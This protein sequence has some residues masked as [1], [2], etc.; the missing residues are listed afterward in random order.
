MAAAPPSLD[1]P[2]QAVYSVHSVDSLWS[3]A[4]GDAGIG[5]GARDGRAA[6]HRR[7]PRVVSRFLE[8]GPDG[9][10][11]VPADVRE[12]VGLP[13][14][15]RAVGRQGP[16]DL[17]RQAG[18]GR[19]ARRGALG[20][21]SGI[22][23][24][25]LAPML[26]RH[27]ND[28]QCDRFLRGM[29]YGGE[30]TCQM[31]SEPDAGSD[32][33]G[34]PHRR[35]ARRRR[36]ARS[37]GTKVWTSNARIVV[38]T[39][40]S[41]PGRTG[42]CPSTAG[43][44]SSSCPAAA[45]RRRGPPD[46]ADERP[47]RVQPRPLRRRHRG[48]PRPAR[49]RGRG[50]GRHAD[51]P[52]LREELLQ[53]GGPRGRPVR[54]CRPRRC[55]PAELV[56]EMVRGRG[57]TR[58]A[59]TA[60]SAG[61]LNHL[62]GEFGGSDD[63]HVRQDLGRAPHPPGDHG[64][65][66]PADAQ[67][68]GPRSRGAHLED[69]RLGHHPRPARPRP[70]RAG[71]L[72]HA[73]RRRRARRPASRTSRCRSPATSIAGG[74]DE[75]QRNHLAEKVLGLPRE[76]GVETR[77]AVQRDRPRGVD[78]AVSPPAADRPLA[79]VRVLD[80]SRVVAGPHCTRLLAEL[81]A[82]VIKLEPPDGDQTRAARGAGHPSPP[83]FV[84]L[85][86]AKRLI[87]VDLAQPDGRDLV[88]RLAGGRRR[89]DRELPARRDERVGSRLPVAGG[90]VPGA[91]LRLDLRLRAVGRVARP[92]GRTRRSSTARPATSTPRPSCAPSR[93]STT[94]CRSPTWPPPRT[95]PSPC[96]PP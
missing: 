33:A 16:A 9:R 61:S 8:P 79:G 13:D 34:S 94:R 37:P 44:R 40:C 58:P 41:S 65:H 26:F 17:G 50:L 63:P 12:R 5:Q 66:E 49:R 96:W 92:P 89:P 83:G 87:A 67:L 20:P 23:P 6:D 38:A 86:L 3:A 82:D 30:T 36:V 95:P 27:G 15:A 64:L 56:D 47:G 19:A 28:E 21:P 60:A 88:R 42:T 14:L 73:G 69:H 71:R 68:V 76:P 59:A 78:V 70:G 22:G 72:R 1:R 45:A 80:L 57:R 90:R 77:P 25:L 91:R 2:V 62:V 46:P 10:R 55:R 43:C 52:H 74:T 35:R 24:T 84:Q 51:V 4:N 48:R 93:S 29:A 7:C 18:A 81:G 31:L 39:A 85:N 54:S 32:L 75:I 53:P 11:V